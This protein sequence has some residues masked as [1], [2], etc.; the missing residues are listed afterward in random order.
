V[1]H[2]VEDD[3]A[4]DAAL[5]SERAVLYKHSPVCGSSLIAFSE[6]RRFAEGHP[7]TPVYL[8]DVIEG[9]A[10]S[11]AAAERLHVTHESPQAI[12]ME[13]GVP[14][15]TASHRGVRAAALAEQVDG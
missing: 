13:R 11:E 6:M 9:R 4:L 2:R 5:K 8:I 10:L 1:I 14:V 15:W 12:L 3:A 7:D